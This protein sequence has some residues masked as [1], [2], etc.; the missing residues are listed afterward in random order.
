[1]GGSLSNK[2]GRLVQG[3]DSDIAATDTLYFIHKHEVPNDRD[4][5]YATFVLDHGPH[6]T[7]KIESE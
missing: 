5:T 2:W 1:M 7:K 4:V 3:N 6:K